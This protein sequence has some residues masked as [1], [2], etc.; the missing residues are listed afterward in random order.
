EEREVHVAE[1]VGAEDVASGVAEGELRRLRE[2]GDVKPLLRRARRDRIGVAYEVRE[3]REP[4]GHR[5]DIGDVIREKHRERQTTVA[6]DD[7]RD[8]PAGDEAVQE[9]AVRLAGNAVHE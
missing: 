6:A 2:S 8:V 1:A 5:P 4:P 9:R 7:G 3:L